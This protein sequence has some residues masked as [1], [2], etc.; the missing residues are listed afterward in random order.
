MEEL[1]EL[2]C[3][4]GDAWEKGVLEQLVVEPS[5]SFLGPLDDWC[6]EVKIPRGLR[7]DLLPLS[8]RAGDLDYKSELGEC[9][10]SVLAAVESS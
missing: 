10:V 6:S 8:L 5:C 3:S 9:A 7:G 2:G 4:V 1:G